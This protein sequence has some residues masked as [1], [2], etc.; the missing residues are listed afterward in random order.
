MKQT[1]QDLKNE[2]ETTKKIQAMRI[3]EMENLGKQTDNTD[4]SITYKM[5]EVEEK[6]SGIED[7]IGK[8]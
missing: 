8:K 2:I 1:V 6:I 3:L 5:Q 4:V 7:T